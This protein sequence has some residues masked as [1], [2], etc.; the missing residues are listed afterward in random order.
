MVLEAGRKE[1]AKFY[2]ARVEDFEDDELHCIARML[3]DV[4][5][6]HS[7]TKQYL[8]DTLKD[9]YGVPKAGSC[10]SGHSTKA[11]WISAVTSI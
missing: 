3:R 1:R 10:F 6:R 9:T 4:P 2:E 5:L 8:V 7:F 11:Y